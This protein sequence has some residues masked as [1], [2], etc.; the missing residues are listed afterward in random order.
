MA[1]T[2]VVVDREDVG[3]RERIVA[4]VTFDSSYPR[5][6]EEISAKDLGFRIGGQ[7]F[8]VSAGA[9]GRHR[10][11][12]GTDPALQSRATRPAFGRLII[13]EAEPNRADYFVGSPLVA[14]GTVDAAEILI[15]NPL[16]SFAG[17]TAIA[18]IELAAAEHAF[19][20]TTDDIAADADT[21][22]E[23]WYLLSSDD[24]AAVVVTPGTIAAEG[25]AVPPAIPSDHAP[26]GLVRVVV[27][28]GA[29]LFNATTDDLDAAHLTTT[30][31]DLDQEVYEGDDLAALTMRV[32]AEGR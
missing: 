22:Q 23:R 5:G 2:I 3:D 9:K 18:G 7:L 4:D 20:A 24:G 30:F 26:I 6:G 11:E 8:L 28:A 17:A 21:A 12:F 32:V 10:L 19:T 31:F 25:A 15:T 16:R 13:R 1:L 27:E 14:I 29:T